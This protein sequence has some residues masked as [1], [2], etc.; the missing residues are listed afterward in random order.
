MRR[1]TLGADGPEVSALCLGTMTWGT[2]TDA[3]GAHRQIAAALDHGVD[4]MDTAEMYPTP[5]SREKLGVTEEIIGDWIAKGGRRDA[6]AIATKV[7][8]E[9]GT[10]RE[11]APV[12]GGVIREA[13]DGSLRRL[14]TDRID[15]YQIHWPNRGSYH[16]RQIWDYAPPAGGRAAILADMEDCLAAIGEEI[17]AGRI[18]AWGL[19]NET[20]WGM[21]AWLRLCDAMGVPRPVSVQ[22]EYSLLCRTY[23]AD[24]GELGAIEE[25]TLLAFSPLATG[26]LTG[27]Y[28]RDLT[29]PGTRRAI[30]P[31]LSGR[32]SPRVWAA[33]EAYLGIAREAGL[34]P[35]Q[36]ALAWILTR[37]F[38]ALPIFGATTDA[39][40]V[41]ALG[42]A[43]VTLSPEV[44]AAISA[45]HRA[46]PMPY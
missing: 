41:R 11:G 25:V 42:A 9:G 18:R 17:R 33:V 5:P 7:T 21:A 1:I 38:P 37:P 15:L 26:L 8:G 16:F 13:L 29:P 24:M 31:T 44:L 34:D 43:G 23:D 46:H 35:V 39:Q 27:K 28:A 10:A 30:N 40:L 2:Q 22:N 32:A 36:M 19:S 20:A 14:R 4:F 6:W 3:A 45:A 12:T